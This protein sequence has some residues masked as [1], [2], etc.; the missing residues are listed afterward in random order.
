M[1]FKSS[2]KPK[3]KHKKGLWSPE[4]DQRLR[5][6]VL[7]HGHACWSSVPVNA[8]PDKIKLCFTIQAAFA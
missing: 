4:E 6:Y 1:G 2:D 7:K 5:N 8:D 3:L